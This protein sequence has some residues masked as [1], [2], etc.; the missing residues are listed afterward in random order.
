MRLKDF[1]VVIA[2]QQARCDVDQFQ[3]CIDAHAH[4]G[5]EDNGDFLCGGLNGP[6]L[7]VGQPRGAD[8]AVD[9]VPDAGLQMGV[10]GRGQGEVNQAVRVLQCIQV[11]GDDD[12]GVMAQKGSGI[13]SDS[14][15][16]GPCQRHAQGQIRTFQHGL[17]QHP[18]HAAVC[19]SYCNTHYFTLSSMPVSAFSNGWRSGCSSPDQRTSV[20]PSNQTVNWRC[21]VS[22]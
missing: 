16:A 5:G 10:K 4:V 19:T 14:G 11:V 3:C 21:C 15:S 17:N 7:C 1:S 13:L 9:L 20:S 12:A 18:A 8:D 22:P 2:A 6:G